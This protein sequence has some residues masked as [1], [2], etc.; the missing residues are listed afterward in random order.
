MSA[1]H[2][3]WNSHIPVVTSIVGRYLVHPTSVG[4]VDGQTV[5]L[6]WFQPSPTTSLPVIHPFVDYDVPMPLHWVTDR[7]TRTRTARPTRLSTMQL[8]SAETRAPCAIPMRQKQE[9][10]HLKYPYIV[11]RPDGRP[12][13]FFYLNLSAWKST[14]IEKPKTPKVFLNVAYTL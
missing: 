13:V 4:T 9:I 12:N 10:A 11:N 6:E 14:V 8:K 5:P 3:P 1:C 7:W 2:C